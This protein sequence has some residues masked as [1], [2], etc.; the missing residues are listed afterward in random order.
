MLKG[1]KF[2]FSYEVAGKSFVI[3]MLLCQKIG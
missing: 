1:E 3:E 2:L